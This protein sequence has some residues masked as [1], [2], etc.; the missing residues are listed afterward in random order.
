M[1]KYV[2]LLTVAMVMLL[3]ITA[4]N[5]NGYNATSPSE[6]LHVTADMT[7][8]QNTRNQQQA[9]VNFT[10]INDFWTHYRQA[11]IN[12]NFDA[13]IAVANFPLHSLGMF[14]T[15]PVIY[16][17]INEFESAF[18]KFLA[19]EHYETYISDDGEITHSLRS[20]YDFI[21]QNEYLVFLSHDERGALQ[22]NDRL[23][24][25]SIDGDW[26][27]GFDEI[28]EVIDG[29][30]RLTAFFYAP[31]NHDTAE[32]GSNISTVTEIDEIEAL[33][34]RA[35]EAFGWFDMTTMPH[36]GEDQMEDENGWVFVRVIYDGINSL[37]DLEAYLHDIFTPNVVSDMFNL[38]PGRFRDFDGVLYVLGADRGGMS[39]RGNEVHE[40]IRESDQR[41]IYRV[42]VDVL[43]W[44]TLAVT[45]DTVTY[46]FVLTLV[47]GN[48]LFNN[49]NLT[50]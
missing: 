27:R 7:Q 29:V 45:V 40:I 21:V 5:E 20:N 19:Q 23:N 18:T 6:Q 32:I 37:A 14:Y 17:D 3:V 2:L 26:A 9:E 10:D 47:D 11:V 24:S 12:Q 44:E 49:F 16:I 33:Y 41:I 50:H 4:C 25:G 31:R 15:D 42:T 30:W 36:D 8:E 46:D 28:F 48:W 34:K 39:D 13:L 1:K 22:V 35:V 43:D 38:I